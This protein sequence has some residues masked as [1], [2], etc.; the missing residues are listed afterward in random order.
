M[1]RVISAGSTAT[2]SV[3][4]TPSLAAQP[5]YQ[6]YVI[7]HVGFAVLP[8]IAGVDKFFHLLVNWDQYLRRSSRSIC[9]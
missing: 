6:A 5:A 8:V 1:S 9:R 2:P 4:R 7:L 3:S